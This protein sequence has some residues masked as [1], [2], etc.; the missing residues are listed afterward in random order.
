MMSIDRS[1]N[2]SKEILLIGCGNMGFALLKGWLA[3]G[4]RFRVHVVEPDRALRE[5]AANAGALT[6]ASADDT[7]PDLAVQTIVLAVKPQYVA[8]S[9]GD[10]KAIVTR[11]AFVLSVAA[12]VTIASME[13]ALGERAPIVRCMPNTPA[14][15][16][17]GALVCCPNSVCGAMQE[18][19]ARQLLTTSG[20]VHFVSDESLMDAVT[21]VS[22]S[23]P[24]YV[25]HFI[26]CLVSAGIEAG[27]P[28]ELATELAVQTTYG[29]SFLAKQSEQSA[30]ELRKQVTS[31]HG[32]TAAALEV[33]MAPGGLAKLMREAVGAARSRS[34]EL[35]K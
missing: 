29:A 6:Y 3:D 35:G 28:E 8:K 5:R 26:E 20:E 17:A 2:E 33:L 14:A 4:Q 15:I 18:A 7:P 30:S 11:G 19:V 31:P 12:G 23:G 13:T 24:A 21:A 25:F 27:L 34:I 9:L 1:E 22:G 16:G 10:Y 32:T